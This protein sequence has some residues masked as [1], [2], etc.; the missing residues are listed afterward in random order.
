MTASLPAARLQPQSHDD[1]MADP[2]PTPPEPS[3]ATR[4][5]SWA[6]LAQNPLP[7]ILGAVIV[8]LLGFSLTV[9]NARISDTNDRITRLEAR[10]D[11][12][13]AEMDDKVNRLD[14]KVDR[15]DDKVDR[16]DDKIDEVNLKLTALIVALEASGTIDGVVENLITG[17]SQ[18]G[19]SPSAVTGR[20]DT[21]SRS[22]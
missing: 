16:L 19:Y 6:K 11:D 14:D 2:R 10:L 22:S 17:P 7:T 9:T 3:P 15:L 21:L 8:V 5:R 18:A 4:P 13:F 20:I 12:R 1:P